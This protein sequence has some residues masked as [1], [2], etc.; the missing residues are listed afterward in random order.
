MPLHKDLLDE[1]NDLTRYLIEQGLSDDQNFPYVVE[2]GPGQY[3]ITYPNA[4]FAP[5]LKEV[6]YAEMYRAQ[7]EDRSYN[8]RML[9]GALIQIVMEVVGDTPSRSRMAFLPAPDLVEFQNDPDLYMEDQLYADVID[10]RVVTVPI[11]FDYDDREGF[12]VP[13]TH[14][15]SHVTLGQYRGCRIPATCGVTPSLFV[16]FILRSF[17]NTALSLLTDE[18]PR[19]P[20]RFPSSLHASEAEV[21]HIGV[22][23][24]A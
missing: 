20:L 11:R 23:S 18:M 10:R 4:S 8:I 1:I 13:L 21:V 9:D 6:P 24:T 5:M 12:S 17:Y 15:K 2:E 7:V 16:E 3:R 19:S 14:P 22:P